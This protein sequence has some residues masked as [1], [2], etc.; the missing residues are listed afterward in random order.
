MCAS[1]VVMRRL[2]LQ[3]GASSMPDP[4]DSPITMEHTRRQSLARGAWGAPIHRRCHDVLSCRED[5]TVPALRAA[6]SKMIGRDRPA[7]GWYPPP[8]LR[9][10]RKRAGAARHDAPDFFFT[11]IA[12][13]LWVS[14]GSC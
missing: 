9:S 8:T 7:P 3:E 1:F 4:C 10:L 11:D 13:D 14:S 2:W 6:V 5:S 12:H